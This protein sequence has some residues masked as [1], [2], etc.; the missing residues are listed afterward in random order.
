MKDN[1]ELIL[2]EE[3]EESEKDEESDKISDRDSIKR[4]K[5]KNDLKKIFLFSK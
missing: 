5:G 4:C 3:E 1:E 2:D